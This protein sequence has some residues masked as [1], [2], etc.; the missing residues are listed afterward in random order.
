MTKR[1]RAWLFRRLVERPTPKMIQ[2]EEREFWEV[3]LEM[4]RIPKLKE[5]FE[6]RRQLAYYQAALD[7]E[8]YNAHLGKIENIEE[9]I[10]NMDQAK[11]KLEE[12]VKED[13]KAVSSGYKSSV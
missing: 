6:M 12:M 4:S 10:D 8:K 13:T 7:K 11:V 5:M 1:I 3:Y 9:M 2:M